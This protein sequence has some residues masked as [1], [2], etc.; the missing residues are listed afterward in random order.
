MTRVRTSSSV[1]DHTA[2]ASCNNVT[3]KYTL[4]TRLVADGSIAKRP[5]NLRWSTSNRLLAVN[6][7]DCLWVLE[8]N[9]NFQLSNELI[10]NRLEFCENLKPCQFYLKPA[11]NSKKSAQFNSLDLN[12]RKFVDFAF[13]PDEHAAHV[14]LVATLADDG[15]ILF[16]GKT[17]NSWT[18]LRELV[19]GAENADNFDRISSFA[20]STCH[21][22][23]T[24]DRV[25][26][27][28]I[29]GTLT[30]RLV[31]YKVC[32]QFNEMDVNIGTGNMEIEAKNEYTTNEKGE[33][34]ATTWC[35][36]DIVLLE[37][38]TGVI[39]LYQ[40]EPKLYHLVNKL[41]LWNVDNY[42]TS[43][44]FA[45]NVIDHHHRSSGRSSVSEKRYEVIFK[46]EDSVCVARFETTPIAGASDRHYRLTM[47]V[48][49]FPLEDVNV[50]GVF[51][52]PSPAANNYYLTFFDSQEIYQ[53]KLGTSRKV[54][55]V[56]YKE[57]VRFT[58][59]KLNIDPVVSEAK[60]AYFVNG[61]AVTSNQSLMATLVVNNAF[62][63]RS[64]SQLPNVTLSIYTNITPTSL[65]QAIG[66][67]LL[68]R[69]SS[70]QK[71]L[72]M[73]DHLYLCQYYLINATDQLTELVASLLEHSTHWTSTTNVPPLGTLKIFYRLLSLA[74]SLRLI[75]EVS[76]VFEADMIQRLAQGVKRL[77]TLI[78][79]KHIQDW[80][81]RDAAL[82]EQHLVS[83]RNLV[84]VYDIA[85]IDH[86][87]VENIEQVVAN[88]GETRMKSK[89]KKPKTDIA[90]F[91][92]NLN[93]CPYCDQPVD[94][95]QLVLRTCARQRHRLDLCAN[96]CLVIDHRL[97]AQP[98]IVATDCSGCHQQQLLVP[99]LWPNAQLKPFERNH[100]CL[101]C[102]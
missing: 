2:S 48:R 38:F 13:A 36:E 18:F 94:D 45:F 67:Q 47:P 79:A 25:E 57:N 56:E 50:F 63:L 37:L 84:R 96:S 91:T 7:K 11:G 77:E 43:L 44:R 12:P 54:A 89:S 4:L 102:L 76:Y 8:T 29:V 53:I 34:V 88:M 86:R 5:N 6:L 74:H 101:F 60:D 3:G 69:P 90:L 72:N 87:L 99:P 80:L 75:P 27:C 16:Y 22:I 65:A 24:N 83:L 49:L 28:L 98:G 59:L 21:Q 78:V 97:D 68:A 31:V 23:V 70:G 55:G 33:G 17:G 39:M 61:V 42:A 26:H 10:N 9:L 71:C 81:H 41:C 40:L 82:D 1:S 14:N 64:A 30:G 46:K 32:L 93:Q 35:Y 85:A 66:P 15:C 95:R 51:H 19:V 92:S 52:T 62:C 73:F 100:F 20:W 58:S